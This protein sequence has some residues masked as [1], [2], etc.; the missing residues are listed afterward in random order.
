MTAPLEVGPWPLSFSAL[1]RRDNKGLREF[2]RGVAADAAVGS[3]LVVLAAPRLD[4]PG[5]DPQGCEAVLV[6]ASASPRTRWALVA[7]VVKALDEAFCAGWS[8]SMNCR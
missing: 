3:D 1:S 4:W 5:V 7:A 6:Q 8:N 2:A